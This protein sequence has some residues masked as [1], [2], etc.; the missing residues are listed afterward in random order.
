MH[1]ICKVFAHDGKGIRKEE[2]IRKKSEIQHKT[3]KARPKNEAKIIAE[4]VSTLGIE[5][6]RPRC[7]FS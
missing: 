1:G 5:T 3:K 2:E 4:I 7:A 6:A